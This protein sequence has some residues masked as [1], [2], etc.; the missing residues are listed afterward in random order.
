MPHSI[1]MITILLYSDI[2]TKVF[3]FDTVVSASQ[4]RL[5]CLYELLRV[6][7]ENFK[8]LFPAVAR[9]NGEDQYKPWAIGHTL[10]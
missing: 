6:L 1:L 7:E 4:I 3:A 9:I 10:P 5:P 2:C 8:Q